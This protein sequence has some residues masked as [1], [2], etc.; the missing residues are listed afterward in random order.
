MK[1][2]SYESKVHVDSKSKWKYFGKSVDFSCIGV[3]ANESCQVS[4]SDR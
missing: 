3:Y 4:R 2:E 1:K